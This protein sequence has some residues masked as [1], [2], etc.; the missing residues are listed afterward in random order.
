M[1]VQK[2]GPDGV[3]IESGSKAETEDMI[4]EE[5][6][7]RFKLASD[8]PI[9]AAELIHKLGHLADTDIAVQIVKISYGKKEDIDN[10][11]RALIVEIGALGSN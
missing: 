9:S 8:A 11:T 1:T 7:S 5:T 10:E 6:E 3:V 2:I 4:F